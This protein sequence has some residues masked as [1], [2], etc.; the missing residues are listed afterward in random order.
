MLPEPATVDICIATFLR[1][2]LLVRLLTS[3]AGMNVP[4]SC[5]VRI[6]IVDNDAAASARESVRAFEQTAPFPVLYDVEPVQNIAL[7]RNRCLAMGDATYCAFLDDDEYV[8]ADW[9][10]EML[11]AC[12]QYCADVVFGPVLFDLGASAPQWLRSGSFYRAPRHPS[13]STRNSGGTGNVLIRR[14][15]LTQIGPWFDPA[16]GLTGGEDHELFGRICQ[17]GYRMV[18]C[19]TALVHE[20]VQESRMTVRYLTLRA[21]RS[22]QVFAAQRLPT[23]SLFGKV[24]WLVHRILLLIIATTALPVCWLAGQCWGVRLLQKIFANAGQLSA[25]FGFRYRQYAR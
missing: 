1:P 11:R 25:L 6:I 9:L 21:L 24:G 8:H 4:T 13:G 20:T 14:S 15:L 23:L 12:M 3:L 17:A 5:I 7:A 18:W 22:G 2:A 16:F 19:D 10:V